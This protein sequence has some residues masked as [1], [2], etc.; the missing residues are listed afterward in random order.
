MDQN[1]WNVT[2]PIGRQH[3]PLLGAR[4]GIFKD[5]ARDD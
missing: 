5:G 1:L 4:V 2:A 3:H